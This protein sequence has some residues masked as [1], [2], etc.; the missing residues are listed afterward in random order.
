[1]LRFPAIAEVEEEHRIK[2]PFGRARTHIR[3]IGEALHLEREPVETL[4]ELRETIGEY[5]FAGQYQQ[6][7]A[8]LEGGM[9][10][11]GWLKTFKDAELPEPFEYVFQS[12]DTANKVTEL[13]DYSVCTSWGVSK[14]RL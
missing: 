5:N 3:H 10:K 2:M 4:R 14:G 13:S 11:A 7:P 6:A 9:I 12:W 1:M 8:P